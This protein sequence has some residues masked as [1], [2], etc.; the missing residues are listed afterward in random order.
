MKGRGI[1]YAAVELAF[2]QS[3]AQWPRAQAHAAFCQKFGRDDVSLSNFCA[4]CKRNG[5]LTGR[6]GCFVEGQTAFN[7]GLHCAP[8]TG[9]RH[10]NARK[11]HFRKGH[12]PHNSKPVGHERVTK[13][14]YIEINIDQVNP[15]TGYQRRYVQK[16]RYLWE[17]AHG[18][19]PAGHALKCLDGD[20]QN[21]APENWIAV[22]RG[23]LPRLSG[24]WA[25]IPYDQAP[26]ELKP[27]L[28]QVA[29]VKHAASSKRTNGGQK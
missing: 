18:P 15:H 3:V 6:D 1:K 29:R 26:E 28:L 13:D 2:I 10:P 12:T 27:L 22:P 9:G 8:G 21:T 19:V 4:L 5:W 17:I 14:G 11:S 25:S 24:R 20:R 7:K 23:L 16:H